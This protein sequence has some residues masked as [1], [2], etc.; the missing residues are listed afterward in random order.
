MKSGKTGQR[1]RFLWK[2]LKKYVR[3]ITG[4]M[5]I[6]LSATVLELLIPY[7]MEHL[8]DHVVPTR[9]MTAVILWGW[10]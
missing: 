2:Y 1:M 9:D 10:P 3:R 5:G 6:K 4:V 8:I 7:V